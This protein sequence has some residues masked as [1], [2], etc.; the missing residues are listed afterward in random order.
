MDD[1]RGDFL[2]PP[3]GRHT[4]QHQLQFCLKLKFIMTFVTCV[5]FH[6]IYDYPIFEQ[7]NGGEI[8]LIFKGTIRYSHFEHCLSDK[9]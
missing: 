8:H 6:T 2:G 1:V 4:A 3:H 9:E 5:V 7:K